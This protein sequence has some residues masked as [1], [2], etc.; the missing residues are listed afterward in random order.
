[1]IL[2]IIA[3]LFIANLLYKN[4]DKIREKLKAMVPEGQPEQP[5]VVD[6]DD[7]GGHGLIS[8]DSRYNDNQ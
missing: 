1:M 5:A 2:I 6:E 3:L 4:A 7:M 8:N